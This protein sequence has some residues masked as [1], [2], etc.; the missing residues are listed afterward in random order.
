VTSVRVSAWRG[1]TLDVPIVLIP[2]GAA[3]DDLLRWIRAAIESPTLRP[4][5]SPP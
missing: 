3:A 1:P 5:S 2:G 4:L